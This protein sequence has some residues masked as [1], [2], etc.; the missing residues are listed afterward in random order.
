MEQQPSQ[1]QSQ[2]GGGAGGGVVVTQQEQE[3]GAVTIP[4]PPSSDASTDGTAT[5]AVASIADPVKNPPK[6]LHV[7]NIPFRFRDPDLRAMFGVSTIFKYLVLSHPN[8]FR[9]IK[10]TKFSNSI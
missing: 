3:N 10:T 5:G 8:E 7:S 9:Q 6:R 1:Q 2:S 4:Q